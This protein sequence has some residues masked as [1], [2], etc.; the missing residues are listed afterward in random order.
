MVL[1]FY[2]S[3]Y[4]KNEKNSLQYSSLRYD[5]RFDPIIAEGGDG[6]GSDALAEHYDGNGGRTS[7][8]DLTQNTALG[9]LDTSDP[10]RT[11]ERLLWRERHLGW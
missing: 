9:F 1:F 10:G 3:I 2:R 11:E 6:V 4:W 8:G 7:D 5:K